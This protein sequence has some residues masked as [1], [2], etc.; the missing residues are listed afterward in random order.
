VSS[1]APTFTSAQPPS[2]RLEQ[3]TIINPTSTNLELV[4][5]VPLA[6]DRA[7]LVRLDATMAGH[8]TSPDGPECRMGRHPDNQLALDDDGIS[9]VHAR[10]Y[11]TEGR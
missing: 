1:Q 8:V 6:R 10:I 3:K 5:P 2:S 9:R 7:V 11:L 4:P